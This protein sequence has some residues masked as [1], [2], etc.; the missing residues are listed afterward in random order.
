M[1]RFISCARW[2]A[3]VSLHYVD[4]VRVMCGV[5]G[6]QILYL[7]IHTYLCFVVNVV[8]VGKWNGSILL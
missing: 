6:R 2:F 3:E 4:D 5:E 8:A 7:H 1:S